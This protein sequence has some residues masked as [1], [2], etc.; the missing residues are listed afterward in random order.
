M[1]SAAIKAINPREVSRLVGVGGVA[2]AVES[3]SGEIYVG[4]CVDTVSTLGVCAER[5]AIFNMITNGENNILRVIAVNRS[6][7]PF[8]PVEL[9]EKL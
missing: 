1:Y 4:V 2:A 5:N 9:V 6:G 8:H 7:K 3:V